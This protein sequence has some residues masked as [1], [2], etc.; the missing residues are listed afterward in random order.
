MVPMRRWL[1]ATRSIMAVDG[2]LLVLRI[3][4]GVIMMAHGCQKLFG[5]FGGA[6]FGQTVANF[7]TG[8]DLPPWLSIMAILV[9]SCAG[10]AVCVGLGTRLAALALCVHQLAAA[11]L[12]HL[13]NGFFLN[14]TLRPGQGHGVEMN[15]ALIA[16]AVALVLGGSGRWG[17]DARL[18]GMPPE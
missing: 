7:A 11:W 16:I 1:G 4:L 17:L 5:W 3:A 15:L 2:L 9:E 10:L 18:W 13:P 12:V 14:W 8:L 6:G